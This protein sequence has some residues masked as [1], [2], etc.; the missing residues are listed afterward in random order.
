MLRF[1]TSLSINRLNKADD[2]CFV[3]IEIGNP[4]CPI[5][6]QAFGHFYPKLWA[7]FL[8]GMSNFAHRYGQK[9]S[10]LWAEMLIVMAKNAQRN[11]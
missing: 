11:G 4:F 6:I 2:S 8:T 5:F 1:I 10:S 9:C 3:G 7:S